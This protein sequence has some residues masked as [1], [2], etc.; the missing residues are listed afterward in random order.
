NCFSQVRGLSSSAELLHQISPPLF[1]PQEAIPNEVFLF[2]QH[3]P[4]EAWP[5]NVYPPANGEFPG[6]YTPVSD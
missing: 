5:C 2:T 6:S 1:L 4:Q 3:T